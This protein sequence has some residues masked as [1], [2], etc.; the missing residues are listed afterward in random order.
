MGSPD[1]KI[2]APVAPDRPPRLLVR[3]TCDFDRALAD[4]GTPSEDIPKFARQA[5]SPE[6]PEI[7]DYPGPPPG[8][9]PYALCN[10]HIRDLFQLLADRRTVVPP[11]TT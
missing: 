1:R 8:G 2:E 3:R 7:H 4:L 9:S 6:E 11:A 5:C 10:G